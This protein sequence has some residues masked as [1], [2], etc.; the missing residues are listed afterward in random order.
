MQIMRGSGACCENHRK[1]LAK[2]ETCVYSAAG[3]CFVHGSKSKKGRTG[4]FRPCKT[5]ELFD[6]VRSERAVGGDA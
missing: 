1:V 3:K 2:E 6:D 4:I 5:Q